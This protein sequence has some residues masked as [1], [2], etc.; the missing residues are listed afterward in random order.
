MPDVSKYETWNLFQYLNA[1]FRL[2]REKEGE[3]IRK[4]AD[5]DPVLASFYRRFND[6]SSN[7]KA[8][9]NFEEYGSYTQMTDWM[10]NIEAYYP[11]FTKVFEMGKTHEGRSIQ[12]IKV[13]FYM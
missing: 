10:R 13:L 6:E 5:R 2:L 3:T 9:Y 1:P 4:N 8:K 7:N 11:S 12:G